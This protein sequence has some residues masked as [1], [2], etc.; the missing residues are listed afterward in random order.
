MLD[1]L[2]LELKTA[3][4]AAAVEM[5]VVNVVVAGVMS[6]FVVFG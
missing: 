4:I 1:S 2:S 5:I 6:V 3:F